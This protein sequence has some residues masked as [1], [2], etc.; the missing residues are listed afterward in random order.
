MQSP[1]LRKFTPQQNKHFSP[2]PKQDQ[3]IFSEYAR[4]DKFYSKFCYL[5]SMNGYL[6]IEMCFF[7]TAAA[8]IRSILNEY[9]DSTEE[10][11]ETEVGDANEE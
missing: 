9:N 6:K 2:R 7:K 3:N 10:E 1:L 11:A 5:F 8:D 4:K